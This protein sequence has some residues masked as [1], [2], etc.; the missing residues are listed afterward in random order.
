MLVECKKIDQA[1]KAAFTFRRCCS[2]VVA[3]LQQCG[4]DVTG[5]AAGLSFYYAQTEMRKDCSSVKPG[6][7][8]RAAAFA[9]A[10]GA[11]HSKRPWLRDLRD[12][13]RAEPNRNVSAKHRLISRARPGRT[14][15]LRPLIKVERRRARH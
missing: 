7:G 13:C 4:N 5:I 1:V 14:V 15:D 6:F 9:D 11:A 10:A 12:R 2:C 3:F 8:S